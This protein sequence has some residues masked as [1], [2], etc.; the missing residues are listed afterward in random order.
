M[1]NNSMWYTTISKRT[2]DTFYSIGRVFN[3]GTRVSQP[4]RC[5]NKLMT[6]MEK[7]CIELGRPFLV[8][9]HFKNKWRLTQR[10]KKQLCGVVLWLYVILRINLTFAGKWNWQETV[11][12]VSHCQ[13]VFCIVQKSIK[14]KFTVLLLFFIYSVITWNISVTLY[15]L[16]VW[17]T[18]LRLSVVSHF[19]VNIFLPVW[20]I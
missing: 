3:K 15:I 6:Q 14:S 12:S 20:L 10:M 4:G 17:I 8:K 19:S 16:N 2:L 5:S 13:I 9:R 1:K 11:G 18:N 7:G